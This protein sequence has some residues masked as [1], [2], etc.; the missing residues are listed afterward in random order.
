MQLS[1][2][3]FLA[4]L[5]AGVGVFLVWELQQSTASEASGTAGGRRRHDSG[6]WGPHTAPIDWCESNYAVVPFVAEFWNT[7]S[8][9]CYLVAAAVLFWSPRVRLPAGGAQTCYNLHALALALTGVFSAVFHATLWWWGQKTDE[10]CEN[11]ALLALIYMPHHRAPLL[12]AA[13][14]AVMSAGILLIPQVFAELHVAA[15]VA[16]L[17]RVGYGR[18]VANRSLHEP[19]R[20]GA[21]FGLAGFVCWLVD[22]ITCSS[23]PLTSQL[24]QLHSWWHLFTAL[25]LYQAA[26]A[27]LLATSAEQQGQKLKGT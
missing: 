19:I 1:Q 24:L 12:L 10:I 25:G 23:L 8:C 27:G 6:P 4:S 11:L 15:S 13:H 17:L 9:I 22:K 16:C 5:A 18:A 21:M 2:A 14:G 20:L 7:L 3:F 26:G